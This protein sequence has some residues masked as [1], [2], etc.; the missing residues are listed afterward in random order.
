MS[1]EEMKKKAQ[2]IVDGHNITFPMSKAQKEDLFAVCM[3]VLD[4]NHNGFLGILA[5]DKS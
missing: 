2:D 3:V 5:G 4:N 1:K